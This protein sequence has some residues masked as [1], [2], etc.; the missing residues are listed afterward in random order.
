[1][2]LGL[3]LGLEAGIWVLGLGLEIGLFYGC[4]VAG[5][6]KS[7][8]HLSLKLFS[9][10]SCFQHYVWSDVKDEIHTIYA[11]VSYSF[12]KLL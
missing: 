6:R 10:Y 11:K 1:M 12:N 5:L 3:G 8:H 4:R 7:Q 9:D 2:D